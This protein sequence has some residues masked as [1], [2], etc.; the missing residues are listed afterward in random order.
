MKNRPK[1]PPHAVVL[2]C[3]SSKRGAMRP[4]FLTAGQVGGCGSHGFRGFGSALLGLLSLLRL[5]TGLLALLARRLG[6]TPLMRPWRHDLRHA[7]ALHLGGGL[8]QDV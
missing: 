4:W 6:S 1:Q 7:L 5:S 8:D 2:V 3:S